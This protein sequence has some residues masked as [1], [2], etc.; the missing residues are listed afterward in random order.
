M[1]ENSAVFDN[2]EI[3]DF[4][5]QPMKEGVVY[6]SLQGSADYLHYRLTYSMVKKGDTKIIRN[7]LDFED[8]ERNPLFSSK[9]EW[10]E[11][12]RSSL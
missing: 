10:V 4:T 11:N 3:I 12:P 6:K 5:G 8:I 2:A 7:F 9:E 1:S